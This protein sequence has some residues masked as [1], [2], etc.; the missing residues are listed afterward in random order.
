MKILLV[1][2]DSALASTL[3]EA[4]SDQNYS[5]DVASDGELA[6]ARARSDQYDLLLLDVMLPRL[7]GISLCKLLRSEKQNVPI[8]IMTA[9]GTSAEQVAGLDAGADDYVIKPVHLPVLFARLR[10][11]LR[12]NG[13]VEE[14][15]SDVIWGPIKIERDRGIALYDGQELPLTPK[16]YTLLELLVCAGTRLVKR[17]EIAMKAWTKEQNPT[18]DTLRSHIKSLRHKLRA[19]QAPEDLI[20]TVHSKGFRLNSSYQ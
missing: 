3:A 2:D 19:A 18:D 6:L 1:E 17:E 16:E 7:D 15:Q 12:R 8:L 4:L 13:A 10:A 9:C 5:V 20:E 11:L 14:E